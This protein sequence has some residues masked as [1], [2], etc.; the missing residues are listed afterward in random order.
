M[1]T[2]AITLQV[3]LSIY[4]FFRNRARQTHRSVE[5][6]LLELAATAVAEADRLAPDLA[7][8]V[9]GLKILDDEALWRAARTRLPAGRQ[10]QIEALN[11]KQQS[12]GLS[13]AERQRQEQ[14]LNACDRVMLVRAHAARLLKER[15]HDVSELPGLR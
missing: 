3:P 2:Q 1:S 14:L 15:G 9:A 10:N 13:Q 8:A 4:E 7:E 6:E 12:E 11:F 5:G